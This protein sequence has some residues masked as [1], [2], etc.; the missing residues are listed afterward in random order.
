VELSL[1]GLDGKQSGHL[2]VLDGVFAAEHNEHVVH[3][4][5]VWFQA[6][7]RQGTHAAK[8]RGFVSGGGVKPWKQKG[9]GRARAGSSRSP[10]WR[11]GGVIFPPSPRDHS[12]N[13]PKKVRKLALKIVLSDKQRAG[14]I[15]VV[16]DIKL[17]GAKTKDMVKVLKGLGFTP[18]S[19]NAGYKG[20]VIVEKTDNNLERAAGNIKGL[21]LT[22]AQ[23]IN[24]FDLLN[25]EWLLFSKAA[26]EKV[27]EVL[28]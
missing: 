13:L 28:K 6:S 18:I 14:A 16:D 26:V 4:A 21:K 7:L 19:H 22:L 20:L 5:L 15:K 2:K 23:E 27:Q 1:I 12:F 24:V 3:S 10:L 11:K 17:S 25:S 8:T 9:T